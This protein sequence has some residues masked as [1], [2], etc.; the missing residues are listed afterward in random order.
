MAF[1]ACTFAAV[2][3]CGQRCTTLRRLLIHETHFDSFVQKLV[4]AYSTVKIGD[5]LEAGVLCGPLNN[6]QSIDIFNNALERIKKEGGKVLYGGKR[7]NRK[8]YFV[9]PTI[10]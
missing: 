8:G 3:T 6:P 7:I 5:P 4:K 9:E 1:K 10:V 2:G